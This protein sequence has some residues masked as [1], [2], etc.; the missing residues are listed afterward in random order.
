M[1]SFGDRLD[2]RQPQAA[3]FDILGVP[4]LD[5]EKLFEQSHLIGRSDARAGV[6]YL[7]DNV[8]PFGKDVYGQSLFYPAVDLLKHD[9]DPTMIQWIKNY[10]FFDGY[11]CPPEYQDDHPELY[12]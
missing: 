8:I 5:A 11:E 3:P 2:N 10:A 1:P 12:T 9:T 4:A 7:D 6:L